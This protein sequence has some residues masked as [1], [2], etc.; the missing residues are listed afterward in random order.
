[1]IDLAGFTLKAL[2]AKGDEST[3]MEVFV[4]DG[5]V[6]FMPSTIGD[7]IP[8]RLGLMVQQVIDSPEGEMPT[9]DPRSFF[10]PLERIRGVKRG[11]YTYK[12]KIR[13]SHD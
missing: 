12:Y 3:T 1:M 8:F 5:V 2:T 7:G 13:R 6:K 9:L 11:D 4:V 10:L